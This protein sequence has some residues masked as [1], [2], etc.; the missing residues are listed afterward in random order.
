MVFYI[1]QSAEPLGN[2]EIMFDRP[3]ASHLE[4]TA[5]AAELKDRVD[6]MRFDVVSHQM[7]ATTRARTVS[8][9]GPTL[10]RGKDDGACQSNPPVC[11]VVHLPSKGRRKA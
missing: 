3:F 9:R 6:G 8:R 1:V 4:A 2:H 10:S 5:A 11:A 7:L